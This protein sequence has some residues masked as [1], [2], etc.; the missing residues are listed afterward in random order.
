MK[1]GIPL[2][3]WTFRT[4]WTALH[5]LVVLTAAILLLWL[6]LRGGDGNRALGSALHD[7][8]D[9][10]RAVARAIPWPWRA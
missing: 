2:V 3:Y 10:Q 9:V 6:Y 1:D 7:L 5:F 8:L 4:A